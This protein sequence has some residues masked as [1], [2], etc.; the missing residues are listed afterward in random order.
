MSLVLVRHDLDDLF[1]GLTHA[2]SDHLTQVVDC[3]FHVGRNDALTG[4]ANAGKGQ[5]RSLKRGLSARVDLHGTGGLG[6]VTD[7][8][9][10]VAD[11]VVDSHTSLVI[12]AAL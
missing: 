8:T 4:N 5:K 10:R 2:V 6:A 3:F 12:R 7:H 1:I 9:C 11:Y